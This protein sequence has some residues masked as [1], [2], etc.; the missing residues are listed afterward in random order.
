MND[1]NDKPIQLKSLQ[2]APVNRKQC[3]YSKVYTQINSSKTEIK[4]RAHRTDAMRKCSA[5]LTAAKYNVNNI[6]ALHFTPGKQSAF[7]PWAVVYILPL[8][9]SLHFSP[10]Q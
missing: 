1:G 7:Y 3:V 4:R 8:G 10:G 9:S 5:A 6:V 2:S